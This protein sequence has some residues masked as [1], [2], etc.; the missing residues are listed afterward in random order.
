MNSDV[1]R[2]IVSIYREIYQSG[3]SFITQQDDDPEHTANSKDFIRK[4]KWKI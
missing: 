3:R 2:N 4:K 1:Y